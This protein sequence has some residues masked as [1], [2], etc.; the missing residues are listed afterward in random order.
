MPIIFLLINLAELNAAEELEKA[1]EKLQT[2]RNLLEDDNKK[3]KTLGKKVAHQSK[4][5]RELKKKL[6][7][8]GGKAQKYEAKISLLDSEIEKLILARKEKYRNLKTGKD[9]LKTSIGAIQRM[10]LRPV[11][12]VMIRAEDIKDMMHGGFLLRTIIPRIQLEIDRLEKQLYNINSLQAILTGKIAK[13]RLLREALVIEQKKLSSLVAENKNILVRTNRKRSE[14]EKRIA[15]L[16]I[17]AK[18]LNELIVRLNEIEELSPN[19]SPRRLNQLD[20]PENTF[21]GLKKTKISLAQGRL[22]RPVEGLLIQEFGVETSAGGKTRGLIWEIRREAVIVSPW[23]GKIVY[24]GYFRSFG[25]ILIINHGEGYHSLISGL[26]TS[27]VEIDQWVLRGEPLG[28]AGIIISKDSFAI[29]QDSESQLNKQQRTT[30]YVEFRKHGQ[31]INPLP[32]M[33][34]RNN[35]ING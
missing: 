35:R 32:W 30:L 17:S 7:N 19:Y 18:S 13:Q 8:V 21:L 1:R 31:P 2:V 15:K 20:N 4:K 6:R 28:L 25:H 23:G 27:F 33:A 11:T 9:N 29:N 12:A 5:L 10:S 26:K 22:T 14:I 16:T 3:N 24:S 34:A